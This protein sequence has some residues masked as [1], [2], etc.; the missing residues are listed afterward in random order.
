[1]G[2]HSL[3]GQVPFSSFPQISMSS[4]RKTT[5][6]IE[7]KEKATANNQRRSDSPML[8]QES[9]VRSSLRIASPLSSTTNIPTSSQS[10]S[11]LSGVTSPMKNFCPKALG[12]D[13][14]SHETSLIDATGIEAVKAFNNPGTTYETVNE[15]S[16]TDSMNSTKNS[17]K[18]CPC[19]KSSGG[20]SWL[21][22]CIGCGQAWHSTCSNLKGQIP[23][24]MIGNLDH[25]LYPWCFVCP[26][27]PPKGNISVKQ[28]TNLTTAVISDSIVT[29]IEEAMKK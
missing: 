13:E 9:G 22:K 29:E 24:S 20:K 19:G 26:Y 15:S 18:S 11:P 16:E 2:A 14:N 6:A 3:A 5:S 7:N 27:K 23:K 12:Q 25:W 1:M 21:L 8:N 10:Q 17:L 4:K 28:S